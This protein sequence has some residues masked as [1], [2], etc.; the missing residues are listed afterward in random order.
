MSKETRPARNFAAVTTHDTDDNLLIGDSFPPRGI[1]VG[2]AGDI[3]AVD[4]QGNTV[5]FTAVP[6]GTILPI[7]PKR[8]GT[9]STATL[10][11]ALY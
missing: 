3:V 9:A 4:E 6:V 2:G 8:I 7:R 1:Y 5:T 10:M 11:V